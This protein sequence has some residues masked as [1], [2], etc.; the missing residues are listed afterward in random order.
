MKLYVRRVAITLAGGLLTGAAMLVA[1]PATAA[2]ATT[3]AHASQAAVCSA[4]AKAGWIC[5]L[6]YCD[7]HYCYYD[8]YPTRAAHAEGAAPGKTIKVPKG[9]GKPAAEI[10]QS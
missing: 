10:T 7:A 3:A 1:V 4:D 9:K 5:F 2:H 6:R 8:C